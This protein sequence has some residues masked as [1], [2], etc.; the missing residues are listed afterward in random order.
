MIPRDFYHRPLTAGL[1]FKLFLFGLLAALLCVPLASAMHAL[2]HAFFGMATGCRWIGVFI[3]L[4]GH[5]QALVNYPSN[6]YPAQSAFAWFAF[7]GY[8]WTGALVA[9]ALL[10][11]T[12]DALL[13]NLFLQVLGFHIAFWG[14]LKEAMVLWPAGERNELSGLPDPAAWLPAAAGVVLTALFAVRSVRILGQGVHHTFFTPFFLSLAL[15]F[16]PAA[17]MAAALFLLGGPLAA[18]AGLGGTALTLLLA[19]PLF[20]TG[21]RLWREP[22]F[23]PWLY[24]LA[25]AGGAAA[26]AAVLLLGWGQTT[27][28]LTWDTP[29]TSIPGAA[30]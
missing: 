1:W 25:L 9:A 14:I 10:F 18:V 21:P 30:R 20:G 7:G 17:G 3:P 6:L 11:P 12:A 16:L 26:L 13:Q 28:P 24:G 8:L 15:W 19:S 2:G 4:G 27:R 23:A 22:S 29:T 5:V